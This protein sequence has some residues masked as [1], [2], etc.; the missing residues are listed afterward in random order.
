MNQNTQNHLHQPEAALRIH[1]A[2]AIL[3][4]QAEA[5]LRLAVSQAAAVAASSTASNNLNSNAN[6]NC[7][8]NNNQSNGEQT[9]LFSPSAHAERALQ[10]FCSAD[11]RTNLPPPTNTITEHFSEQYIS[12]SFSLY[13][14]LSLCLRVE[15]CSFRIHRQRKRKQWKWQ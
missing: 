11:M 5:A 3:R 6:N 7:N 8:A 9:K 15:K 14:F 13:L 2:E 4:S 12:N 1:Q 10:R